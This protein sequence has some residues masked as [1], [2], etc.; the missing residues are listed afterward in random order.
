MPNFFETLFGSP[1]KMKQQSTVTPEVQKFYDQI[2]SAM[3]GGNT[4]IPG[5]DYLQSLFSNDPNAFSEFEAPAMRQFNEQTIPGI[6]ERFSAAGSGSRNSSAFNNS[7]AM[8]GSRLS[9]NLSSQ[10]ANLRSGA[11]NQLQGWGNMGSR[12]TFENVNMSGYPG[13]FQGAAQGAGQAGM[14]G[15]QGIDW[16][17]LIMMITGG[18]LAGGM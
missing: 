7:T 17:K 18:P 1:S 3:Q 4:N 10:R 13:L 11:M 12:P 9:E 14:Q 16:G 2:M 15:L 6:A 8:A 5:I